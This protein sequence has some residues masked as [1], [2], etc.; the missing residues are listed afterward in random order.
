MHLFIHSFIHCFP[1]FSHEDFI[2]ASQTTTF[3][4]ALP[5]ACN[6]LAQCDWCFLGIHVLVHSH[7]FREALPVIKSKSQQTVACSP[8]T[9]YHLLNKVLLEHDNVHLFAYCLWLLFRD[10]MA[11]KA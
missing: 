1:H 11:H 10:Y 4:I 7:L 2:S 8:N 6:T 5:S 3:A 9:T